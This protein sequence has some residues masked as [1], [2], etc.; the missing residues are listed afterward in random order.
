M[1]RLLHFNLIIS[2]KITAQDKKNTCCRNI[3]HNIY[4]NIDHNIYHNIDHNIYHNTVVNID[5]YGLP[6]FFFN[7]RTETHHIHKAIFYQ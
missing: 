3:D 7:L 5:T 2:D 1:F 6:C 4:H